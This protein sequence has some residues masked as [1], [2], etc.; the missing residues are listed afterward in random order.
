MWDVLLHMHC[1]YYLMNKAA[2]SHGRT[3]Y[4]PVGRDIERHQLE[5]VAEGDRC[6]GILPVV[7]NLVII[8]RLVE[9][10]SFKMLVS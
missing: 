5:L 4:S 9:M 8:H 1:F 6:P 10:G 2:L 3:E 7:H